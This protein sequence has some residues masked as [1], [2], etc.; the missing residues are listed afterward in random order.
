M[1]WF[2]AV[3]SAWMEILHPYESWLLYERNTVFYWSLTRYEICL[4]WE[5]T[6]HKVHWSLFCWWV[7]HF[8]GSEMMKVV[9]FPSIAKQIHNIQ[10]L[11]G[12]WNISVWRE[13]WRRGGS[14]WSTRTYWHSCWNFKQGYRLP[15]WLHCFQVFV[16]CPSGHLSRFFKSIYDTWFDYKVH[17]MPRRFFGAKLLWSLMTFRSSLSFLRFLYRIL[18]LPRFHVHSCC[19][20]ILQPE[21]EAVDSIQRSLFHLL[22][23][24]SSSCCCCSVR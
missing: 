3:S 17:V 18:I 24:S 14:L 10:S 12:P 2:G 1:L 22:D 6:V 19:S 8:S 11:A 23:S 5:T 21:V 9:D 16:S 4:V 15:W 7:L 20:L 13:R